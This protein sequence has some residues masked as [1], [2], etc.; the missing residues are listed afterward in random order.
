[1]SNKYHLLILGFFLI[2]AKWLHV[3]RFDYQLQ[4]IAFAFTLTVHNYVN[5][6]TLFT[7][8]IPQL[9]IDHCVPRL[10]VVAI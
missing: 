2:V 8:K 5:F 7:Q 4:H 1:M 6:S 10:V 9:N 3:M